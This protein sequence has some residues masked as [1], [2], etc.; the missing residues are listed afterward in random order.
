MTGVDAAS[1]L[2][3]P[4][5]TFFSLARPYSPEF[6]LPLFIMGPRFSLTPDP[7]TYRAVLPDY[8]LTA[9]PCRSKFPFP[10]I[11]SKGKA[12]YISGPC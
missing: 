8:F 7:V 4:L 6:D 2:A 5:N 12:F 1:H 3:T 9:A 11:P 10:P